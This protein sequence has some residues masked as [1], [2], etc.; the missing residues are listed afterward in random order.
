VPNAGARRRAQFHHDNPGDAPFMDATR[1]AKHSLRA[2]R[3]AGLAFCLSMIFFPKT[4]SHF[5]GSCSS[6]LDFAELR[7]YATQVFRRGAP[8]G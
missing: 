3:A 2:A 7:L 1:L 8:R 5:S 4:G 6:F